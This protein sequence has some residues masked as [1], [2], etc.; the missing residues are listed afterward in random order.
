MSHVTHT[1]HDPDIQP[2]SFLNSNNIWWQVQFICSQTQSTVFPQCHRPSVTPTAIKIL[3]NHT[4]VY[5]SIA[6]F[7]KA[8]SRAKH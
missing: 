7:Q 3:H 8:E 5:T 4:N 1:L 2:H 6:S